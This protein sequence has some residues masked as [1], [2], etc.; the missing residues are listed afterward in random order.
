[1]APSENNSPPRGGMSLPWWAWV[2]GLLFAVPCLIGLLLEQV[3]LLSDQAEAVNNDLY[4]QCE[5]AIGPD[6][7]ATET[8]TPARESDVADE[9]DH[10]DVPTANP[11][12]SATAEPDD[13]SVS[14]WMRRC[15][16]GPMSSAAYQMPPLTQHNGGFESRCAAV[17]ARNIHLTEVADPLSDM[18]RRIV[19]QASMA[20]LTDTCDPEVPARIPAPAA[21]DCRLSAQVGPV[22]RSRPVVLPEALEQQAYCG[23]RVRLSALSAGDVVFWDYG[24]RGPQRAGIAL[25]ADGVLTVDAATGR[26]ATLRIAEVRYVQV[27]RVL[28][29]AP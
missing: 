1:M 17:L 25:G 3:L 27:K 29:A 15:L 26:L 18:I 2:A 19:Y 11:Y 21:D 12:A 9:L 16:N 8:R 6:P 10:S 20:G 4:D 24:P 28:R 13:A 22:P 5:S 7:D 23:Q 14:S